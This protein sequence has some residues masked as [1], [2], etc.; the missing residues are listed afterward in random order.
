MTTLLALLLLQETYEG[1]TFDVPPGKRAELKGALTFNDAADGK[2][3]VVMIC[4]G[5]PSLGDAAKD[6]EAEWAALVTKGYAVKGERN[7][8]SAEWPGG[9]TLTLG[10]APVFQEGPGDFVSLLAV[11]SGHGARVAVLLNFNDEGK[12]P[13]VDKFLQSVRLA[14]PAPAVGGPPPLKGRPWYRAMSQYSNWG[15]NPTPA[16]L[17]K[18]TAQGYSKWTYSFREDGTYEFTGEHSRKHDEIWFHEESGAWSMKGELLRLEPRKARRA[19]RDKDGKDQR[20]PELIDLEKASY[21]ARFHYFEGIQEWNLVLVPE[22]GKETKRDGPWSSNAAF[23]ASYLY[24]D[25]R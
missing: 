24:G 9:W 5:V 14:K 19:L 13:Q 12:R 25:K 22:G 3:C 7:S 21:K 10:A 23:P 11:F 17:S 16:E 18:L 2:F 20:E 15:Y 8:G 6:F 1:T 4:K